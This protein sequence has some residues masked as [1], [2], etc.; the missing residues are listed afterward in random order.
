[1]RAAGEFPVVGLA[2]DPTGVAAL[3]LGRKVGRELIYVGKVSAGWS[4]AVS[5]RVRDHF[6]TVV[7]PKPR[8]TKLIR[9]PKAAWV[10]LKFVAEIEYR[11]ITADGLLRACSFGG[12]SNSNCPICRGIGWGVRESSGQAVGQGFWLRLRRRRAVP[13]QRGRWRRRAGRQPGDRRGRSEAP[14]L[15]RQVPRCAQSRTWADRQ[16]P[17]E[18]ISVITGADEVIE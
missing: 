8:L 16:R 9:A 4:R 18:V 6:D 13:V 10:E 14:P 2:K 7:I 11:D 17:A 15:G 5:R 3:H 1:V 12:L